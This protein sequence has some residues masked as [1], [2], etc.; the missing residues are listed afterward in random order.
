MMANTG[1][2]AGR[3]R[4]GSALALAFC[5]GW[6]PGATRAAELRFLYDQTMGPPLVALSSPETGMQVR[7]GLFLDL[8]RAI[9]KELGFEAVFVAQ[10]RRRLEQ[11][12]Q[13][14]GADVLCFAHPAWAAEPDKL[15][16]S[17]LYLSDSTELV[18]AAGL[19]IPAQLDELP[20]GLIGTVSGYVYPELAKAFTSPGVTRD[21]G[22]ND[23]ANLRK[24]LA[25]RTQYMVTHGLYLDYMLQQQPQSRAALGQRR[26]LRVFDTRCALAPKSVV[27]LRAFDAALQRLRAS[28][29]Y[30][31]LLKH[32]R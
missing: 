32:Y 1:S 6:M 2:D 31:A 24:L 7:G 19:T 22:P 3:S 18:A 4:L 20:P 21:D 17:S 30:E 5:L 9:A 26:V 10:P 29:A 23:E 28:G 25:G 13:A 15:A 8:N 27:S 12:L 14:G 11:V 16:W